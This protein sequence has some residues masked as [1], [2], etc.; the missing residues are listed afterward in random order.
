MLLGALIAAA[1]GLQIAARAV[2]A[3]AWAT[4][5]RELLTC[6]AEG[7]EAELTALAAAAGQTPTALLCRLSHEPP[8]PNLPRPLHNLHVRDPASRPP[9][10]DAC[11][12]GGGGGGEMD[13]CRGYAA[14]ACLVNK[15]FTKETPAE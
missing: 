11:E 6:A 13:T 14:R 15:Y 7:G 2:L 3:P 12:G 4:A 5:A 8:A 1:M 9:K 10:T